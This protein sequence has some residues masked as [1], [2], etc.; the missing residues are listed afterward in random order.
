[1]IAIRRLLAV[2]AFLAVA[3]LLSSTDVWGEVGPNKKEKDWRK[4]GK[5]VKPSGEPAEAAAEPERNRFADQPAVVYH[6]RD[7]NETYFALQVQPKLPDAPALPIDY[8]VMVDTS[9]SKAMGPLALAQ[10]IAQ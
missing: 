9:A 8:L 3:A 7:R 1:M 5:N 10:Q 2:S 6:D 4:G